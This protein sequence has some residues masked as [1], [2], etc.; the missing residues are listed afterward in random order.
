MTNL[1]TFPGHR[2]RR[3]NSQQSR[4]ADDAT[5]YQLLHTRLSRVV[6]RHVP[7][8]LGMNEEVANKYL[9]DTPGGPA[10]V[11]RQNA[12]IAAKHGHYIHQRLFIV[13]EAI[14]TKYMGHYASNAKDSASRLIRAM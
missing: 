4:P 7:H 14:C 5:A 10:N 8:V 9:F 3:G 1:L 13:L 11:C 12:T 6:I 2:E